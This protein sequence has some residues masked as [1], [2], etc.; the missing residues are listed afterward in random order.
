MERI[1]ALLVQVARDYP[2]LDAAARYVIV[3]SKN[4][5]LFEGA[6]IKGSD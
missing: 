3:E 4:P 6:S 2:D 5:Q 1:E